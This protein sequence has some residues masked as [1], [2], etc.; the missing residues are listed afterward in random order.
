MKSTLFTRRSIR[1][2]KNE[3]IKENELDYVLEAGLYAPSGRNLQAAVMVAVTD[4]ALVEHLARM[5]AQI[6]ET[7]SDPFYGAPCVV[8]VFA[9]PTVRTGFEDGCLVMG[10]M[11]NAAHE[12]GLGSCWIHRARQMFESDEGKA[13]MEKWGVPAQYVGIGNCILGYADCEIPEAAPR[14]E[15]RIIKL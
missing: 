3:Q 6:M 15:G 12:I 8:I 7:D 10:N 1:R 9:D 11:L 14:R 2:Y 13:L 4:K 5:N